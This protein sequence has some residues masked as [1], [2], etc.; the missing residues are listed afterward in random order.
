MKISADHLKRYQQIARLLWKYGRSDLARSLATEQV[1]DDEAMASGTDGVALP[2]QL[3]DDLEAMGPTF[4]KMG[5]VLAS[6]PD[7]LPE[8]Y[9]KALVRLQDRVK[10]FA[11]EDVER[12]VT[13]EIGI[14]L[15]KAFARFDPEPIAAASL[16]Q[17]HAAA[18]RDGRPVVVKVQRPGIRACI[19]HDFEVLAEIAAF[20]DLHTE[21]GRQYRFGVLLEEFRLTVGQELNYERE[22]QN[23]VAMGR[24]LRE[25]A[26]IHV[27]QP[28]LDYSTQ[29]VLTMEQ[30]RGRKITA[31]SPLSLLETPGAPLVEELVFRGLLYG[32][33]EGRWNSWD[34]RAHDAVDAGEPAADAARRQRRPQRRRGRPADPPRAARAG[35]RCGRISPPRR[36][37]AFGAA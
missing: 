9:L 12:I 13:A 31:I 8:R 21:S 14:R 33:L 4:V 7:L 24:N 16:G 3:A 27:P 15:S 29:N 6:R 10:P 1:L 5:Q 32:W 18:L 26:L 30:V 11:F 2:E 20:L 28:I 25:F 17:V 23:L 34:G 22:A 19:A 36:P 37:V 35:V